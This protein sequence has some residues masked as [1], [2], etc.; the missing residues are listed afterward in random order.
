MGT[1]NGNLIRETE[2][3]RKRGDR[4]TYE[5]FAAAVED[6]QASC[7]HNVVRMTAATKKDRSVKN[8]R[9]GDVLTWCRECSKLL[10]H[11]RNGK[12]LRR[13]P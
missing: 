7:P 5:A 10:A 1:R 2:K 8:V 3:A 6:T 9:V 11:T 12:S 13:G 4:D